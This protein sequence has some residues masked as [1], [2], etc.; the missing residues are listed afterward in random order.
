MSLSSRILLAFPDGQHGLDDLSDQ[1][2]QSFLEALGLC[3][4]PP[5][6]DRWQTVSILLLLGLRVQRLTHWLDG[7]DRFLLLPTL[8]K[9]MPL[10]CIDLAKEGLWNTANCCKDCHGG[11]R[12]LIEHFMEDQRVAYLCCYS[13]FYLDHT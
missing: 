1:Q 6:I 2:W 4:E 11:Q 3:I 12:G 10:T 7:E 5:A 8:A 9:S 13:S